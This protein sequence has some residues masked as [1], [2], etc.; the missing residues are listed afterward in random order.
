MSTLLLTGASGFV[1]TRLLRLLGAH[2]FRV[3]SVGRHAP[4]T[5]DETVD[6]RHVGELSTLSIRDAV[7]DSHVDAI[8]HLAAAGVRPGDRDA[9]LLTSVNAVLPGELPVLA[10]ELGAKALIVAGSNAEYAR[11]DVGRV[12]ENGTLETQKLYGATK[13]AGGLLAVANGL[14]VR[15]PTVNL[16]FFNVF[17]PGEA[18]HRL[19]PSLVDALSQGKHVPLSAGEQVRDF[20]HVDDVCSAILAAMNAAMDHGLPSGHYNVCTGEGRSVREFALAVAKHMGVPPSRLDFGALPLRPDDVPYL[21]G[22]PR[23]LMSHL[24]WRPALPFD[25]RIAQSITELVPL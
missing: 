18:R 23:V 9:A 4:G 17:G 16:R 20:I 11:N 8:V 19:L 2:G 10:R 24:R 5:V 1:G 12:D 3:I 14:A 22:D 21:V 7:A 15:I 25:E 6:H 13:A